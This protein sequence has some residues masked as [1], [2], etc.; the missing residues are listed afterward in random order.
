MAVGAF[1]ELDADVELVQETIECLRTARTVGMGLDIWIAVDACQQVLPARR[2]IEG[3]VVRFG[4]G[5]RDGVT[6]CEGRV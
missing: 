2:V 5:E 3:F 1:F 4:G 6:G